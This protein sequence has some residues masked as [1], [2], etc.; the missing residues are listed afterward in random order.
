MSYEQI[1]DAFTPLFASYDIGI[2]DEKIMKY[3][4]MINKN[5]RNHIFSTL[6]GQYPIEKIKP[7][8][9]IYKINIF[10]EKFSHYLTLYDESSN[11]SDF[12]IQYDEYHLLLNIISPD[13]F[14]QYINKINKRFVFISLSFSVESQTSGHQTGIIVDKKIMKIYLYDPNGRST[15]FDNI[16]YKNAKKNNYISKDLHFDGHKL[17]DRLMK[18]YV[19]KLN[20]F[21]ADFEYVPSKIWNPN[22]KVINKYVN[23][24]IFGN[25]HCVITTFMFQHYLQLVDTNMMSA[26]DKLSNLSEDE[27][28]NVINNYSFCVFQILQPYYIKRLKNKS[29]VEALNK[30]KSDD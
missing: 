19:E 15:F 29:F 12:T 30:Q 14:L 4:S 27:T 23:N 1:T 26:F 20:D 16:F 6:L 8:Y 9:A 7:E 2:C 24:S 17:I 11:E 28:F 13:C 21:D 10:N 3:M 22:N 5:E 25:G 18:S